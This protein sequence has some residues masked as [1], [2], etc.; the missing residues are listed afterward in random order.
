MDWC[1]PA[2]L[3]GVTS[4]WAA[5]VRPRSPGRGCGPKCA[6]VSL[7]SEGSARG[8]SE[9]RLSL[10]VL[11]GSRRFRADSDA[12]RTRLPENP[13]I[14][15]RLRRISDHQAAGRPGYWGTKSLFRKAASP[16]G[17]RGGWVITKRCGSAIRPLPHRAPRA[18]GRPIA[19]PIRLRALCR[20][21]YA[22]L[23]RGSC[24]VRVL[25]RGFPSGGASPWDPDTHTEK[26][27]GPVDS[28]RRDQG[29]WRV[30]PPTR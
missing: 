12:F 6:W 16:P 15:L 28:H 29:P 27:P 17:S 1:S 9:M 25:Q 24:R 5:A 7:R 11:A 23:A 8:W 20:V 18:A 3:C 2:V 14:R 22:G 4:A 13:W 21:V 30:A 10:T 26:G 19:R